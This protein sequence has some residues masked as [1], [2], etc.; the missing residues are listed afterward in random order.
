V[1]QVQGDTDRDL[2]TSVRQGSADA[3]TAIY[4]RWRWCWRRWRS[5]P[6]RWASSGSS[7]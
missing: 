7:G 4:V 5:W 6:T 3:Y 2:W 1:R